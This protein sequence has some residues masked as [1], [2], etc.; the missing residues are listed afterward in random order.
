MCQCKNIYILRCLEQAGARLYTAESGNSPAIAG[1]CGDSWIASVFRGGAGRVLKPAGS[2]SRGCWLAEGPEGGSQGGQP[3]GISF[4]RQWATKC[5]CSAPGCWL[6]ARR[7]LFI[8]AQMQIHLTVCLG[9]IP[10]RPKKNSHAEKL[11]RKTQVVA[12]GAAWT[13][14]QNA[15]GVLNL[16]F[17]SKIWTTS[18]AS[19]Q[20]WGCHT[21]RLLL[22]L[23]SKW[24]TC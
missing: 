13:G 6:R 24:I 1:R 7:K 14:V 15:Q 23:L 10:R 4:Y 16:F 5:S 20:T 17:F 18:Y 9:Q 8:R 2:V 19:R 12:P 22:W 11:C 3:S 21:D